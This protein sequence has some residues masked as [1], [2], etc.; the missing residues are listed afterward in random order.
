MGKTDTLGIAVPP[1]YKIKP[2]DILSIKIFS[3]SKDVNELFNSFNNTGGIISQINNLE[4]NAYYSGYIVSDSGNIKL[5]VIGDVYV[6]DKKIDE[7]RVIISEKLNNYV[8]DAL[9]FAKLILFKITILGEVGAPGMKYVYTNRLTIL[10]AIALAGEVRDM[11]D[12][13]NV[14]IIRL[15]DKGIVT[16]RVDLTDPAILSST[17]FFIIPN[18]VIYVEPRKAKALQLDWAIISIIVSMITTVALLVNIVKK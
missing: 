15:T 4:A 1:D 14:L 5:P 3:Y 6:K 13:R 11:G 12:R 7:V 18:D 8:Q 10:E 9:V 2:N 16:Y 17:S